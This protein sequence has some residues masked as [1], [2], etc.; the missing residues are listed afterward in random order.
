MPP[1]LKY[2]TTVTIESAINISLVTRFGS[3]PD[4]KVETKVIAQVIIVSFFSCMPHHPFLS[5]LVIF[6]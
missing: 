5:I 2:K 1:L 6:T 4:N 3:S